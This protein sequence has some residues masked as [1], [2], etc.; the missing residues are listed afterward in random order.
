MMRSLEAIAGARRVPRHQP[1]RYSFAHLAGI[2]IE[3][4]LPDDQRPAPPDPR[5]L[6]LWKNAFRAAGLPLR[7]AVSAPAPAPTTTADL[8]GRAFERVVRPPR[9]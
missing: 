4:I 1:R 2:V 5:V 9:S 3:P 6:G 7:E 8:W